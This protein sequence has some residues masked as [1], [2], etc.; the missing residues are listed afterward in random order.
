M[1]PQ[2][3]PRRELFRGLTFFL[4]TACLGT[5]CQ[6]PPGQAKSGSGKA[7]RVMTYNIHHGEGLDE[8]VDLL[9]IAELIKREGADIVALQEVDK[10]VERTARR[11]LP[12]ELAALTGMTCIFS[13][14]Y[15]YQ[16][17]EYGNA[18]LTKFPVVRWTNRHYQMLRPDEQRGILQLVLNVHGREVVFMNTHIDYRPDDSERWSNVGEIEEI[19]NSKPLTLPSDTLSPTG[20]EGRVRGR[21]ATGG[22]VGRDGVKGR[23]IILCGDFND[24]PES[25]VCRRL[26]GTFD[27][28]W[29]LVGQSDGF[30][31]PAANPRKRI[32]Y[33]WISKDKS[34]VPLKAWVPRSDASDHL[35][36][37]AEFQLH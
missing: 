2:R 31:I 4:L 28:T 1:M 14:N 32:D 20:G 12:E 36:V 18:V 24:T 22:V 13:N 10:G 21:R 6:S 26:S 29:A 7:F 8:K 3:I 5:G 19:V 25:R 27:D 33:L 37:V 30:T 17:G 34:L 16:G 35:P 15:H 23:P 9:R 11:D